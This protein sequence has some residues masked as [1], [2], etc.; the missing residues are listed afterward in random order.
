MKTYKCSCCGYLSLEHE[1][2]FTGEIRTVFYWQE[3]AAQDVDPTF[4]TK[5]FNIITNNRN[6]I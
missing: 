5:Y 1:S 3:D 2:P 4:N 6:P